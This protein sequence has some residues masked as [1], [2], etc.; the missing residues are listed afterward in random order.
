[1]KKEFITVPKRKGNAVLC[2]TTRGS[3][4]VIREAGVTGKHGLGLDCGLCEGMGKAGLVRL[5]G[6]RIG[7]GPAMRM[8]FNCPFPGPRDSYH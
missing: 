8:L 2:R 7:Q 1:M 5:S 3:T 4:Q 6:L